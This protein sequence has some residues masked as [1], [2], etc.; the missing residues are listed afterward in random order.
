MATDEAWA[1]DYYG[2]GF[3]LFAYGL[4]AHLYQRALK[5]GIEAIRRL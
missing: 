2:H 5:T 3:R 1:R 4:D